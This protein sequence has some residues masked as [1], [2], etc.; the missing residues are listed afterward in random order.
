MDR[1]G[2]DGYPME[3]PL[4]TPLVKLIHAHLRYVFCSEKIATHQLPSG[5]LT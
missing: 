1:L 2:F 5:Y 3:C 4:S